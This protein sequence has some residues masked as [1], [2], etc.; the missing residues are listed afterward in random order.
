LAWS[1]KK[2]NLLLEAFANRIEH[3]AVIL[4]AA[5]MTGAPLQVVHITSMAFDDTPLVLEMILGKDIR[6][7]PEPI[8][9]FLG[10]TFARPKL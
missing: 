4:A 3:F 10:F 7:L 9:E 2:K 5:A 8:R 6:E 1:R